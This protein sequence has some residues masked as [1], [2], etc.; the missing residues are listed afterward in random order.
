MTEVSCPRWAAL[1]YEEGYQARVAG[2]PIAD[3]PDPPLS[4]NGFLW[5]YGWA[6]ADSD[7]SEPREERIGK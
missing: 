7:L 3:N 4:E 6:D 5:D 1:K 2:K